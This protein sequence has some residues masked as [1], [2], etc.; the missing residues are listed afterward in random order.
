M[1]NP[2][3]SVDK[4][5][6]ALEKAEQLHAELNEMLAARE[7]RRIQ[8]LKKPFGSDFLAFLKGSKAEMINIVAAFICVLLAYQVHGMRAFIKNLLEARDEKES[9]I[10]RLKGLLGVLSGD[11][12]AREVLGDGA[13]SNGAVGEGEGS[14]DAGA[15]EETSFAAQLSQKCAAEVGLLFSESERRGIPG[16]NWIQGRKLASGD[17]LELDRL[18]ERLLPLVDA[19]IRSVVGESALSEEE[20]KEKRVVELQRWQEEQLRRGREGTGE[21]SS[22]TQSASV[23]K[24]SSAEMGGLM[25]VLGEVHSS[26]LGGDGSDAS[27]GNDGAKTVKRTIYAI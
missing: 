6:E 1:P 13:G 23:E 16:F 26:E 14:D 12:V 17:A 15:V 9:E 10:L 25:E 3:A 19:E 11:A 4:A 21:F 18:A 5:Q 7:A 27:N 24:V 20:V 2:V 8:D 22:F